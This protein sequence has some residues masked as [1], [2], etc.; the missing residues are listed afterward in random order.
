[1]VDEDLT[2]IREF[3]ARHNWDVQRTVARGGMGTVH[4][5][6]HTHLGTRAAVK[7]LHPQVRHSDEQVLRFQQEAQICARL[8]HPNLV[9]TLD[10]LIDDDGQMYIIFEWLEGLTLEQRLKAGRLTRDEAH[11]IAAGLCDGLSYAHRQ[12]VVHRDIKPSNIF[13]ART[14]HGETTKI[15][16]FGIARLTDRTDALTRT[17]SCL[18]TPAYMSPEQLDSSCS[19]GPRTDVYSTALVLYEM[20]VGLCPFQGHS[21]ATTIFNVCNRSLAPSIF[22]PDETFRILLCATAKDPAARYSS[23]EVLGAALRR[24]SPAPSAALAPAGPAPSPA[25]VASPPASGR[26]DHGGPPAEPHTAETRLRPSLLVTP[27][28][29]AAA[30][31]TSRFDHIG[32]EWAIAV[33]RNTSPTIAAGGAAL[34]LACLALLKASRSL[35][36]TGS[37]VA[38]TARV[39]V[40]VVWFVLAAV[41]LTL[42]GEL[43]AYLDAHLFDMPWQHLASRRAVYSFLLERGWLWVGV[44][45][46]GPLG[47]KLLCE[48]R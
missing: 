27:L 40:G 8:T 15:L 3:L 42:L 44:G 16:D 5:A 46:V 25:A 19:L 12:G 18:G 22:V 36:T 37:T 29:C 24:V 17:G 26:P 11:R 4:F 10:F 28:L 35:T 21:T 6:V 34:A 48:R 2:R 30:L 1:M 45:L 33:Q 20:L 31:F 7:V 43:T 38:A 23:M 47:H 13:L 9:R 14:E 32:L 41:A 39:A